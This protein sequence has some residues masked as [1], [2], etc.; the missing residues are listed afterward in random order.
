MKTNAR[1]ATLTALLALSPG[2]FAADAFLF[3]G[4]GANGISQDLVLGLSNGSTVTLT[5]GQALFTPGTL[6][7]GWWGLDN[8]NFDANDSIYVGTLQPD[9]LDPV[10][11]HRNF[12]TFSLAGITPG[13]IISAA[14]RIHDVGIS[15]G[16]FPMTYSLFDVTTDAGAL[17]FNTGVNQAIYDDL[18]SGKRYAKQVV[19]SEPSG[20]YAIDLN[21]T[22]LA[23]LNAAAGR[24]FS[25]GGTLDTPVSAVTE[26]SVAALLGFGLAAAGLG[27]RRRRLLARTSDQHRQG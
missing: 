19:T 11:L 9:P 6:N 25:L 12:F 27:Q 8:A 1:L 10:H 4:T 2:A 22:A 13:S 24:F 18:G 15:S 17:N 16:T 20:S 21:D 3:A 23:D 14:L 5:T 26:P 7:Q